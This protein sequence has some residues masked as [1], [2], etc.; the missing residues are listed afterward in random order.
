M[1]NDYFSIFAGMKNLLFIALL[2]LP[3]FQISDHPKLVNL[4]ELSNGF[5]YDM[6]YATTHNFLSE[7]LYDCAKC[8]LRPE[9]A[10]ALIKAN[11][12]FYSLGYRIRIFD[13]YRPLDIQKK[14]W[15]IM[16]RATYL[17]NPYDGGSVHNRGAAID[18]T[19][20]T[21]EGCYVDMGT[22]FDH[23]GKAAHIDNFSLDKQV[24]E[25]RKMLQDGM[26]NVGFSSIRTE[27]WHFNYQ[28]N[29]HYALLNIP[30]PCAD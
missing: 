29:K 2:F 28:K 25:N 16:P 5:S 22:D 1:Q 17:A 9:V 15:K 18:L 8:L 12:H 7:Q 11:K 26:R 24:L 27:W 23:F 20:E 21:L 3:N 19:L 6:R 10:K 13:C 30:L 4:A 14:M